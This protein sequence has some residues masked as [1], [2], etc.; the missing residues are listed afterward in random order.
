MH[1]NQ[2]AGELVKERYG[3]V[4][5]ESAPVD[6]AN[7]SFASLLSAMK[8]VHTGALPLEVLERY[9]HQLSRQLAD[10]KQSIAATP[11]PEEHGQAVSDQ[12]KISLGALDIVQAMLDLLERYI[13]W[14]S[15]EQMA[16]CVDALLN[17]Q[18]VLAGLN[19]VLDENIRAAGLEAS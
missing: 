6:P 19:Q 9:H 5:L 11:V 15:Q 4:S 12:I 10:S 2:A 7:P 17:C 1:E 14:P 18:G 8:E 13:Q 3:D 16:A